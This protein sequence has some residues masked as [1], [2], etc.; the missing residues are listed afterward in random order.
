MWLGRRRSHP[1]LGELRRGLTRWHGTLELTGL[2]RLPLRLPGSLSAPREH[3]A[4]RAA[5]LPFD[6]DQALPEL[7]ERLD[8]HRSAYAAGDSLGALA[9]CSR[10][11]T[12]AEGESV[13]AQR[14]DGQWTLEVA[15]R[16][17]WDPEHTLGF[18][19]GP[20][21]GWAFNSSV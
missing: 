6:W 18:W 17:T 13:S 21:E 3:L 10:P 5:R 16:A 19:F 14:I 20:T 7:L 2:G 12:W 1:S 11:W 4:N 8:I 9:S 15:L